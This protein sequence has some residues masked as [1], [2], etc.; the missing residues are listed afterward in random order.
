VRIGEDGRGTAKLPPG[1]GRGKGAE[2]ELSLAHSRGDFVALARVVLDRAA[3]GAKEVPGTGWVVETPHVQYRFLVDRG[4]PIHVRTAAPGLLRI[5]A[6]PEG[7]GDPQVACIVA[8]HE[9]AVPSNGEPQSVPFGKGE[10]VVITARSGAATVALAERVETDQ[11][12]EMEPEGSAATVRQLNVTAARASLEGG[13]W[14]GAA[15]SAPRPLTWLEDRLGTLE[16]HTGGVAQTLRDGARIDTAPDAYAFQSLTYRRRIES[17]NLFTLASG[18]ARL[19]ASGA[20]PTYGG[21]ASLY[22]DLDQLRLRISATAG[23]FT[24]RV[25]DRTETTLRPRGF[26]EYNARL[27]SDVFFLPR[28]GYDGFYSTI[29]S[30]PASS[31][32]VDDDLYNG[33]RVNRSSLVFLQGLLWYAPLFNNIIYLRTRGTYDAEN[34]AFSH[35]SVRPGT[36]AIFR[37]VELSAFLDA[38]YFAAT[39][40]ARATSSVD[41]GAGGSVIFHVPIVPGS[42]EM[43]PDATT[44][45]RADG[46]WQVLAGVAFVTSFRRGVRDYASVELSFPEETSGGIPWRSESR[47]Q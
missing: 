20:E 42:L 4:R 47:G 32:N 24:Q 2:L 7:S 22:E 25:E 17:L 40:G 43:R 5:D 13:D 33:F 1:R 9:I 19:R 18:V 39:T 30:R 10:E 28:L 16:S 37:A 31:R 34:G 38:Q 26:V 29:R 14:R 21:T 11:R 41:M 6:L 36:F 15:E 8:G 23:A 12:P 44:M 46:G 3:P 45:V 27:A 35:A